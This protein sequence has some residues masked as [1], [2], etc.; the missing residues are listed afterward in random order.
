MLKAEKVLVLLTM[1]AAGS[2]WSAPSA[3]EAR[4][5]TVLV[6]NVSPGSW[7]LC[8]NQFPGAQNPGTYFDALFSHLGYTDRV[9]FKEVTDV[10]LFAAEVFSGEWDIFVVSYHGWRDSPE[11]VAWIDQNKAALESWIREGHGVVSTGGRDPQDL[12]LVETVGLDGAL[13]SDGVAGSGVCCVSMLPGTAL[14]E[15]M[16]ATLDASSSGD[17]T[18]FGAGQSYDRGS[19]PAGVEVAAVSTTD[20]NI[21]AIVFGELGEGAYVLS[22][23]TEITNLPMI[24]AISAC[25]LATATRTAR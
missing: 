3:A 21:A 25:T 13:V 7:G 2:G 10:N 12:S 4:S 20:A 18:L 17:P 5:P 22:G 19:L 6:M 24:S 15:G 9:D 8:C 1:V 11:L 23:S 16:G 14:S